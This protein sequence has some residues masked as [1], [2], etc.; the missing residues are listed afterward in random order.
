MA[1]ERDRRVRGRL[2]RSRLARLREL[3]A[4]R[5]TRHAGDSSWVG[6]GSRTSVGSPAVALLRS[7]GG[8]EREGLRVAWLRAGAR[9]L[10]SGKTMPV[11]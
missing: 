1:R 6:T 11:P 8:D 7:L 10:P 2:S 5:V 9:V 3:V 4:E